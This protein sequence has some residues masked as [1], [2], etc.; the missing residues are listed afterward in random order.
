M[1]HFKVSIQKWTQSLYS[2]NQCKFTFIASPFCKPSPRGA[3]LSP[4]HTLA[5]SSFLGL[6]TCFRY[7]YFYTEVIPLELIPADNQQVM[8]PRGMWCVLLLS[9]MA[10]GEMMLLFGRRSAGSS[11]KGQPHCSFCFSL[12]TDRCRTPWVFLLSLLCASS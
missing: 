5:A 4:P 3:Y 2:R 10:S 7:G 8:L 6:G 9:T 1:D 11:S 12:A